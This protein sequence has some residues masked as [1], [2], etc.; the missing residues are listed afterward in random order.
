MKKKRRDV[1]HSLLLLN[2]G[3]GSASADVERRGHNLHLFICFAIKFPFLPS[4]R[5]LS[6]TT[7]VAV[8]GIGSERTGE[9]KKDRVPGKPS[10]PSE[11]TSTA[12]TKPPCA[13]RWNQQQKRWLKSKTKRKDEQSASGQKKGGG[14][15]LIESI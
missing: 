9:R 13:T 1:V 3:A 10:I 15:E 14:N 6:A 8:A 5:A 4:V 12:K 11:Q 2:S 7:A